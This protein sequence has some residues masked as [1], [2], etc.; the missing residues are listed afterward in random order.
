MTKKGIRSKK[1]KPDWV[2]SDS[3]KVNVN[4]TGLRPIY[5]L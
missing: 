1:C 2:V 3:K 5:K 4:L